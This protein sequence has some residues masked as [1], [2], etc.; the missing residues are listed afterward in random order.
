MSR[1]EWS[2]EKSRGNLRKHGIAFGAVERFDFEKAWEWPVNREVHGEERIVSISLLDGKICTLVYT[3]RGTTIRVISLR[4]AS[5]K[6]A[7]DY[8]RSGK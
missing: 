3:L 6:E 1:F 4:R 7:D 8:G 2:D 5:R